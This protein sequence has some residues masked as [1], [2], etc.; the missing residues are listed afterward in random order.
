[1]LIRHVSVSRIVSVLVC[2][3]A[4]RELFWFWHRA[5]EVSFHH[6]GP[7]AADRSPGGCFLRPAAPLHKMPEL[8]LKSADPNTIAW[9]PISVI[10]A[11]TE[12]GS[13]GAGRRG[14]ADTFPE[15][16]RWAC[17]A[18]GI[19]CYVKKKNQTSLK[20]LLSKASGRWQPGCQPYLL[21]AQRHHCSVKCW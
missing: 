16:R 15:T 6:Q 20:S 5:A 8:E 11:D 2:L 9:A 17:G 18:P 14:A 3:D 21:S 19:F 13:W 10:C 4:C 1:M 12:V 7:C